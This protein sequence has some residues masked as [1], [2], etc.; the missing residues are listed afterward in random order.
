MNEFG[1]ELRLITL[2]G[3]RDANE[4]TEILDILD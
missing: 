1:L 4:L 3:P 2:F